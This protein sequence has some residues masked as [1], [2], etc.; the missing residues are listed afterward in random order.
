MPSH[1]ARRIVFPM[2]AASTPPDQMPPSFV[3]HLSCGV[4]RVGAGVARRVANV[5]DHVV[6]RQS[7]ERCCGTAEFLLREQ[8]AEGTEAANPSP[9]DA[10]V[11]RPV[12]AERE[13]PGL[14]RPATLDQRV[15]DRHVRVSTPDVHAVLAHAGHVQP[16]EPHAARAVEDGDGDAPAATWTASI[17]REVGDADVHA[18]RDQQRP[19]GRARRRTDHRSS[20]GAEEACAATQL[21]VMEVITA[22]A[23]ADGAPSAKGGQCPRESA[24][25]RRREHLRPVPGRP[26]ENRRGRPA[27]SEVVDGRH[28]HAVRAGSKEARVH[29]DGVRS[30]CVR[31]QRGTVEQKRHGDDAAGG[32][33]GAGLQ[34]GRPSDATARTEIGNRRLTPACRGRRRS[35]YD[36][37]ETGYQDSKRL[38]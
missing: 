23:E 9:D 28:A 1:L 30:R 38:D 37:A 5:A 21:H 6:E 17:E 8:D 19:V 12:R 26:E 33:C 35:D 15:L 34:R 22:R 13:Y 2:I 36:N 14:A 16:P 27:P 4:R 20:P 24:P 31:A 3:P 29:V 25:W 11:M 7:V 10:R 32:R 18:L